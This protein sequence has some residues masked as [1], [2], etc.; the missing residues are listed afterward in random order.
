MASMISG[1]ADP[2]APGSELNAVVGEHGVVLVRNGGD[3]AQQ[4]A[5]SAL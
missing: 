3:Q 2:P 1:T 4:E 5:S